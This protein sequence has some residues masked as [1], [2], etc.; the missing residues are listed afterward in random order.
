MKQINYIDCVLRLAFIV[1]A[2]EMLVMFAFDLFDIE[3][4]L[5]STMGALLDGVGMV[6]L[7]TYPVYLWV[8]RPIVDFFSQKQEQ[9]EMLAQALEDAGDSVVITNPNGEIVYVNE[10]FTTVTGYSFDEVIGRNPNLLSS[11]R[12]DRVFYERMWRS[13]LEKGFWKGEIWNKR[14]NGEHYPESLDIRIV[15][16]P[17]GDAKFYVAVFSDL[18]EKKAIEG[19]LMQS[20]KLE[21]LGT[22]VGGVAH[23]FNNLLAAISGKAYL[24]EQSKDEARSRKH[25]RDIQTLAF[26][27]SELVKQL[28]TFARETSHDKQHIPFAPLLKEAIKTA[29]LGIPENI[30]LNTAIPDY[31][32]LVFGDAVHLTQSVINMINNARDALE[33]A[34]VKKINVSLHLIEREDCQFANQC[35]H[36]CRRVFQLRISDTG[37][38]INSSDMERIFE[39]FFTT[40]SPGKGSGLGL[41]TA[42]GTIS[43][44]GGSINVESEFNKGTT[45]YLCLPIDDSGKQRVP[46]EISER[47]HVVN[48]TIL[49]VDDD[50]HVRSV[51]AEILSSLGHHM[52]EACDGEDALK[53][54]RNHNDSID[55]LVTDI[56]MP[57]MDGATLVT[58]VRRTTPQL[59]VLFMTG[60]DPSHHVDASVIDDPNT[61]LI[62]KPFSAAELSERIDRL[63]DGV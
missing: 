39:P 38:G 35:N 54:L 16:D 43:D 53:Q 37:S 56:V 36:N 44:Y 2:S 40:K 45:F 51:T 11:G 61:D 60:Y 3:R 12:H 28:L 14:K 57:H 22:L 46:E 17:K 30:S 6:L 4:N 52:I 19:A 23:N 18:T 55:L 24:A 7:S 29:E 10:A 58:N 31:R 62:N 47:P 21:A 32:E 5:S 9:I 59:P 26:D 41:S 50:P 63:F 48:K 27:S 49:L 42:I 25:I 1:F 8:Y 13:L 34:E 15:R 20:Q 33:G